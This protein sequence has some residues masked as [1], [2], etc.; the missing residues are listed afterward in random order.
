MV[1]ST[2]RYERKNQYTGYTILYTLIIN[3]DGT[4]VFRN[5][6]DNDLSKYN[7]AKL[8]W[9]FSNNTLFFTRTWLDGSTSDEELALESD[10]KLHD[11]NDADVV[12]YRVD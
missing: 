11:I 12:Y 10:G 2:W 5:H 4:G 1:A 7:E 6:V 9:S 8:E 3:E